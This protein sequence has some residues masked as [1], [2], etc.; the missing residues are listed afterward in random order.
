VN[1]R[2]GKKVRAGG[3]RSPFPQQVQFPI[4]RRSFNSHRALVPDRP[5]APKAAWRRCAGRCVPPVAGGGRGCGGRRGGLRRRLAE[6]VA[7]VDGRQDYLR[8]S[9]PDPSSPAVC[10]RS[11]VVE[12]ETPWAATKGFFF[13]FTSSTGCRDRRRPLER[14]TDL[15]IGVTNDLPNRCRSDEDFSAPLLP[16]FGHLPISPVIVAFPDAVAGHE[17][18]RCLSAHSVFRS[19]AAGSVPSVPS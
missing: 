1:R 16:T 13:P 8:V 11:A 14:G 10:L 5:W 19:R 15:E 2:V 17:D 3:L 4:F 9:Q 18:R 12:N 6:T 7:W